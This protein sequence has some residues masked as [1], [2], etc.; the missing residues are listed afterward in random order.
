MGNTYSITGF[1]PCQI[2]SFPWRDTFSNRPHEVWAS[3]HTV[4]YHLYMPRSNFGP[5]GQW[6]P[7]GI[8]ATPAASGSHFPGEGL[9]KFLSPFVLPDF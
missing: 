4:R 5:L 1:T 7:T 9:S 8:V 6:P 2:M 3:V